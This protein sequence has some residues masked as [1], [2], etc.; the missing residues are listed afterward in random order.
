MILITGGTGFLGMNL[1]WHLANKGEKVLLFDV[2]RAE[3]PS[4][5]VQ[6]WDN[7]IRGVIGD[8]M[9]LPNLLST[10]EKYS[11][12]SVIHAAYYQFTVSGD[13]P[14]VYQALKANL[15]GTL[16]VLEACRIFRLRRVS[17]VSSLSVYF[18]TESVIFDE[19]LDLPLT[20]N[21]DVQGIKHAC[22]QICLPYVK[23]YGLSLTILR[24]DRFYGPLSHGRRFP[25]RT[26][27]ENAT[28]NK[29]SD[30]SHIYGGNKAPYTYIKDTAK[31]ISLIHCAKEPEHTIYNVG[32]GNLYNYFDFAE[33]IK[34]VIPDADIR[35][36]K[37][38]SPDDIDYPPFSVER[39]KQEVA[40][41][42]DY[43]LPLAIKDYVYWLMEGRY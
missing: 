30:F 28:A 7:Q 27:V 41:I 33:A 8:I 4:F 35:L 17:F 9:D 37:T 42:P 38:S 12:E 14:S 39:L 22:E 19:E 11:I 2:R 21:M 36:G 13:R 20:S 5:L 6:F 32:E 16:N 1:A 25:I 10:I 43:D 23:E 3:V 40:F 29:P 31:A 18:G 15:D 26:M 24:P 34:Q